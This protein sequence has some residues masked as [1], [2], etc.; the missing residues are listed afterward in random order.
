MIIDNLK[1]PRIIVFDG[2]NAKTNFTKKHLLLR[3]EQIIASSCWRV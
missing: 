3:P 1:T 2:N